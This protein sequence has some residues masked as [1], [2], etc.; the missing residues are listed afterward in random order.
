MHTRSLLQRRILITGAS[1]G[2]GRA[3]AEQAA[4]EGARLV[5]A[6]RSAGPLEELAAHLTRAG[7]EAHSVTADVGCGADRGRLIETAVAKLGGLDVLV[8]NAGVGSWGHFA[9]SSE[10]VLRHVMEVDFFAPVELTRLTVPH[11]ARGT[12]PTIVNVSSMCGRRGVPAW[13][14][15]S[16]AK[17]ALAGFTEA[18]RAELARFDIGVLLIVPGLTRSTYFDNLLRSDGRMKINLTAGMTPEDVA[19]G[20]IRSLKRGQAETILGREARWILRLNRFLPRLLDRLM[21]RRVRQ[22]YA[23]SHTEYSV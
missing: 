12:G 23:E 7:R 2:I 18:L 8:N 10:A 5:L 16:A 11:L 4:R 19:A 9:T 20:V 6:A 22:L 13:S 14:E 3:I 21:A 17:F 15:Y 1:R